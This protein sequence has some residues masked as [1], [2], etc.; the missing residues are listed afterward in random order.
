VWISTHV[1][2]QHISA[3]GHGAGQPPPPLLELLLPPDDELLLDVRPLEEVLLP[4]EL[5]PVELLLPEE[6]AVPELPVV[7]DELLVLEALPVPEDPVLPEDAPPPEVPLLAEMLPLAVPPVD[8]P[9]VPEPL[10]PLPSPLSPSDDASSPATN[11][12]PPQ[13]TL[14]MTSAA[15]A[16]PTAKE[17]R[18][19][20][21]PISAFCFGN[22][23]ESSPQ[24]HA[25][26]L[27]AFSSRRAPPGGRRGP[28]RRALDVRFP[29]P[30]FQQGRVHAGW[31]K[32]G[33][34][35]PAGCPGQPISSRLVLAARRRP[36]G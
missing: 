5:V 10:P 23:G 29:A 6:L 35:S 33:T 4:E 14:T 3:A 11:A 31:R 1:L 26:P 15:S 30:A 27:L 18:M 16:E 8:V 32:W 2:P 20:H 17:D 12:E 13:F 21:P 7:L 24:I 25:G 34:A 9:A 19:T 28:G 36:V 22:G